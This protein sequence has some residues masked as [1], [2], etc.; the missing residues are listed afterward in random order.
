MEIRRRLPSLMLIA[1]G[2]ALITV[3][4]AQATPTEAPTVPPAPTE[5]PATE[6]AITGS[7]AV[8]GKLYDKWWTQAGVDLPGTA[9]TTSRRSA[10]CTTKPRPA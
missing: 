7:V 1:L 9:P 6:M 4:C 5:P 8:G 2:M 3:A 10:W